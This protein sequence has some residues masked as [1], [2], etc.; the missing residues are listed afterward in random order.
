[1]NKEKLKE[2]FEKINQENLEKE[3][4]L[5]KTKKIDYVLRKD[6]ILIGV[7]VKGSRSNLYNSIGE[8]FFFK[9][10][11]S[12]LYLLA[13]LDF[14][15]KLT[16]ITKGTPLF[17]EIGFLT[18]NNNELVVIKEPEVNEYYSQY[19][20]IKLEEQKNSPKSQPIGKS[21][22]EII[23][24]F[25]DKAFTVVDIL[26]EFNLSRKNAYMRINYLKRLGI[27]EEMSTNTNPK[28]FR[29]IN[30]PNT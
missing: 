23:E 30:K 19:Q 8:M 20:P 17:K 29:I 21:C 3:V 11:F 27:V 9:K 25:Q 15:K 4:F 16:Q 2:L 12:H 6:N 18:I 13:P 10:F 26:K 28:M 5:T 24:K 22:L 7:K 14:I 1:M